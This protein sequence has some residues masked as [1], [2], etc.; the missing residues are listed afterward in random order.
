MLRWGLSG[1]CGVG[2]NALVFRY[3]TT[4]VDRQLTAALAIKY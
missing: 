1:D 2:E 4:V 3:I